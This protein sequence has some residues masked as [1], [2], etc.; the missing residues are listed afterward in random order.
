MITDDVDVVIK[1]NAEGHEETVVKELIKTNFFPQ[2]QAIFYER[3]VRWTDPNM[4][5]NLL[6]EQ[7]FKSFKRVGKE[8][9][10]DVLAS[11]EAD[12]A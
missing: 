7:G 4:L 6:E 5:K 9:R 12:E 10:L 3:D 2:V 8:P 1:L 11:R